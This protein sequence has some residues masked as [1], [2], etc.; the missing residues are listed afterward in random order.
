[1]KLCN[2]N[3]VLYCVLFLQT[4]AHG[5]GEKE[6]EADRQTETDR[7]EEAHR[8]TQRQTDRQTDRGRSNVVLTLIK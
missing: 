8:D 2:D 6:T 3:N 7:Q 5:D 1:M 4:G